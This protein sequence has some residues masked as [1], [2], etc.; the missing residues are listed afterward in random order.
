M[1]I[2]CQNTPRIKCQNTSQVY[3]SDFLLSGM[4]A[5]M[6]NE[7]SEHI[8]ANMSDICRTIETRQN[9]RLDAM[10]NA[11]VQDV[12]DCAR[13]WSKSDKASGRTNRSS[14]V[15]EIAL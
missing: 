9:G 6:Q 10:P 1:Q 3:L 12:T 2:I 7:M 13:R 11:E 5:C 8:P 4:S 15:R 14:R